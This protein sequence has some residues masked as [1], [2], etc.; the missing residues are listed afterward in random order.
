MTKRLIGGTHRDRGKR[1]EGKKASH[2]K[3]KNDGR[4]PD[5]AKKLHAKV[6]SVQV[7]RQVGKSKQ[8]KQ[9]FSFVLFGRFIHVTVTDWSD[10]EVHGSSSTHWHEDRKTRELGNAGFDKSEDSG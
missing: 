4:P 7:R 1:L 6:R 2:R 8:V 5:T 9:L 3:I 10:T